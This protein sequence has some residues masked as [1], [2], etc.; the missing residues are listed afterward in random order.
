MPRNL[1]GKQAKFAVAVALGKSLA[2]SYREA[3]EPTNPTA[4]S[5]YANARRARKHPG[6]ARRIAEL[7]VKLLPGPED[8][9]ALYQHALAV[10]TQ[11]SLLAEDDRVRLRAAQ[12]IAAEAEK[13]GK[14][15]EEAR[16]L[17]DDALEELQ[18]ILDSPAEDEAPEK[19]AEEILAELRQEPP[20]KQQV[21]KPPTRETR[22]VEKLV[23]RPGHFPPR[24]VKVAVWN[25]A[26]PE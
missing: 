12:W 17:R 8:M 20:V 3:Y 5:V 25:P 10:G 19:S 21:P 1:T 2:D 23:S 24:F 26:G 11:L 4:V 13:R 14:I 22:Y 16:K 15:A 6:I 9:K 18:A 7:Q